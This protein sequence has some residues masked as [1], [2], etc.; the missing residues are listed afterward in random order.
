MSNAERAIQILQLTNDGD[1]LSPGQLHLLELAVNSNL[2][3]IGQ[4]DF[5]ELYKKVLE[6]NYQEWFHNIEHLTEDHEGYIYWRGIQ[7]EHYS[8]RDFEEEKAD[9]QELATRCRYLE[10]INVEVS[11]ITAIWHWHIYQPD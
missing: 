11:Q 10:S 3:E 4:Q 7:V 5:D 8:H 1:K 9:A 2:S 6:N